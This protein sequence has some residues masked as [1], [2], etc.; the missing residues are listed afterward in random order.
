MATSEDETAAARTAD[1]LE[2]SMTQMWKSTSNCA[3]G[4]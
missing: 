4:G 3:C 2:G 1:A